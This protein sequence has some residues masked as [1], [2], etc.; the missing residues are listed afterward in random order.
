[1][2]PATVWEM[3]EE[4]LQGWRIDDRETEMKR[5]VKAEAETAFD[6]ERGGLFRA[7]LFQMGE[8]DHVLMVNMHHIVSDGWSM[9]VMEREFGELY[10][11]FLEGEKSPLA[12]LEYQ[13]GDYAAWQREWLHGEILQEQVGYWRKQLAG[14]EALD[15]RIG[16]EK[17]GERSGEGAEIGW[18]LSADTSRKLRELCQREG[19][20]VFML[21]L[22]GFQSLLSRYS[23]RRDVTVGIPIAGRRWSETEGMIGFFVNTLAMR[24]RWG[25]EESFSEILKGVRE[26]SLEAH[27][28]QDVP[29]E[30]LVEELQPERDL[31]RTPFFQVMF[32]LQH[33]EEWKELRLPGLKMTGVEIE[34]GMEKF[35]MTMTVLEGGEGGRIA[36]GLS[37]RKDLFDAES[38]RR[39]VAQW[40]ILLRAIVKEPERRIEEYSLLG[41]VERRQV[42]EEW[43]QPRMAYAETGI[44]EQFAT[45]A[46]RTP[47]ATALVYEDRQVTYAELECKAN[48]LAHR[49]QRMGVGPEAVVGIC[50]ERS[51]EMVIGIVGILK[52]GG[53]YLPLDPNYPPERLGYMLEDAGVELLLTQTRTGSKLPPCGAQVLNL[54]EDWSWLAEE[55]TDQPQTQISSQNAAYVIYTSGST[56]RP[57]G[58]VVSHGNV[59][60]L[61]NATQDW[62][63]FTHQDVWTMFHSYAF[64][65]S[66]WELWGALLYGGRLEIVPYWTNRAPEA[67]YEFIR[68]RKVTV[69]N[70]T[71]SA[72]RQL[73]MAEETERHTGQEL[74]LRLVIFGGEALEMNSLGPWFA[75]HGDVR[76]SLVNMYGITETTVHVTCERLTREM[77]FG[78]ASL[79][80]RRIPD[81]QL[82]VLTPEMQLTPI[83]VAGEM[84]V[85]G[86]GLTRGYLNRAELTASRFVP[87]PFSRDEG[88]R[89]YRTGD[90]ARVRTDGNIEYLGRID[91][92]VKIRGHRIELGEIETTLQQHAAVKQAVVIAREDAPGQKRLVAYV[93]MN[94]DQKEGWGED[95]EKSGMR[96][97]LKQSLP[98]YMVPSAFVLLQRLPLTANGKLDRKAL[99]LPKLER[100]ERNYEGSRSQTE[101]ILCGIWEDLLR[102]GRIGV[103]DDFFE[104]G[105]HSLLAVQLISRVRR[106]FGVKMPLRRLFEM[107]TVR[108][109]GEQ[110]EQ[111]RGKARG[112]EDER[113]AISVTPAIELKRG[114]KRPLFFVHGAGGGAFS[115]IEL[116]RRMD[117]ERPLI[118]LQD[119]GID[120]PD[121]GRDSIEMIAAEYVKAVRDIQPDGP[122]LLGGWS[123]GGLVAFEMARL[124][125][126]HKQ[127]IGFLGLIDSYPGPFTRRRKATKED[128]EI[129]L[130]HFLLNLGV[131]EQ[132]ITGPADSTPLEKRLE[133]AHRDAVEAGVLRPGLDQAV[134]ERLFKVYC[135]H[136]RA[137]ES[138]RPRWTDVTAHL[139]Q[140]TGVSLAAGDGNGSS[141]VPGELVSTDQAAAEQRWRKTTS[142]MHL[143]RIPGDHFTILQEP[144]VRVLANAL[145]SLLERI[146]VGLGQ[147]N[148][149]PPDSHPSRLI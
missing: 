119:G 44:H 121:S 117:P 147:A 144:Y 122:Y 4:D 40:E 52:A 35:E 56:G 51:L 139:W 98:E 93:V 42:L 124:L 68:N 78:R 5:R 2:M 61:F 80:G 129:T 26:R 126:S 115:F 123:M 109:L 143:S 6:L 71:P 45:Q 79:I 43:N 25:G 105:G 8:Q 58:V 82:Y 140:A 11:A 47:D 111:E 53:A 28:H 92:Q 148:L 14:V 138:Y 38:M 23:G 13:Y 99:P 34:G 141:A 83:G 136:I 39:M 15:L 86:P 149:S 36:G 67:F 127:A 57:K 46:K 89:L 102:V 125:L 116:A 110:I 108:G 74:S 76:P 133:I 55:A 30:K 3:E 19:V 60:R 18:Q 54:E 7:R 73:S 50:T 100:D 1:V 120:Q 32:V 81:L 134:F 106:L 145:D 77:A 12:E 10:R 142:G 137:T 64:D 97:F 69:L 41:E 16:T 48:Q 103:H 132:A 131:K 31:S 22:A 104:L 33:V 27:E 96:D 9:G 24:S 130:R 118:A 135:R 66:V 112:I 94:G 20:T 49:L 84:Y 114:S 70:Q 113:S 62:F 65:F 59:T 37:Y 107:P 87:N 85:G 95:L 88:E 91:Q 29:F 146:D 75:R 63:Q 21:L 90:L 17:K 101:E 72:F 128:D